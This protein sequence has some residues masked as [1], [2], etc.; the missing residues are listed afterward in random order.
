MFGKKPT[1]EEGED[2]P[3]EELKNA[4]DSDNEFDQAYLLQ[5]PGGGRTTFVDEIKLNDPQ[6]KTGL[7]LTGLDT[8]K[9]K[10]Q[11]ETNMEELK[12]MKKQCDQISKIFEERVSPRMSRVS[13]RKEEREQ[14]KPSLLLMP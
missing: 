13:F 3:F 7:D 11:E 6:R 10:K 8:V 2:D 1:D 12:E 14:S 5:Q 9:P 4:G